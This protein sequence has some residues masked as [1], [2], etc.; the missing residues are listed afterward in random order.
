M[1]HSESGASSNSS[2]LDPQADEGW[3]DVE[4]EEEETLPVVSF[5]SNDTFPDAKSMIEDCKQRYN[6]DFVGAQKQLGS[7]H[8]KFIQYFYP[9]HFVQR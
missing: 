9:L 3:E 8:S 4:P 5:F 6:F 2:L 1:A 7:F